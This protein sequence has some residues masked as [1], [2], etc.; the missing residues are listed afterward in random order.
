MKWK[1][2]SQSHEAAD[3]K[4]DKSGMVIDKFKFERLTP[5]DDIDLNIYEN[6]LDFAL[7]DPAVRNI[8][9]SGAYSSGKSS[10]LESYKK[11]HNGDKLFRKIK[12]LHISLAHFETPDEIN[13]EDFNNDTGN[14]TVSESILEG[15]I[16]NQLIHQIPAKRIPQTNF[17][18][19]K[20]TQTVKVIL[21]TFLLI[22]LILAALFI[23]NYSS[24]EHY[25]TELPDDRFRRLLEISIS[26]YSK[27]VAG[28]GNVILFSILIYN[29]IRLQNDRNILKK[30]SVQGNEIEIFENSDDSF[31][32]K[33]LNEVLY[34][35]ERVDA[36][37]IV[38]EDLDRFDVNR[39][40]ERLHEINTLVNSSKHRRGKKSPLRFLYL[41]RDDIFISKDRTKFFDFIIPVIPVMDGSNSYNILLKCFSES[42]IQDSFDNGFLQGLS[43]YIDDMR[44][45]KNIYNEFLIY[46]HRLNTTELDPNKMLAMI[47][48][49]NIFPRDFADLQLNR[50]FVYCLFDRKKEFIEKQS[51]IWK[52]RIDDIDKIIE[53][54]KAECLNSETEL[55]IVY[56]KKRPTDYFGHSSSLSDEDQIEYDKR[57][58][59]LNDRNEG[60]IAELLSEK[61][62]IEE[63]LLE[64]KFTQ[65]YKIIDN[66][67]AKEVFGSSS[68][69]EIGEK[70]DYNEIKRSDY[71][72]LLKYLIREGYID[73]TYAD[74]MTFFYENSLHRDDKIFLRSVTDRKAK[75][76]T[77][78]L[79]NPELVVKRLK[80]TDFDKEETLNF[81]LLSFLLSNKSCTMQLDRFISQLKS[82]KNFQFIS[83]YMNTASELPLFVNAVN[84]VW[85][86]MF[87]LAVGENL[88]SDKHI[89]DFSLNTLCCSDEAT[90]E[91]VNQ[92]DCLKEYISKTPD[93]LDIT[94]PEIEELI[95]VFSLLNVNFIGLDYEKSD[96]ALFM[97]VYEHSMYEI[98]AENL[99]LITRQ[100]IGISDTDDI[101]HKNYTILSE[102]PDEPIT[103]YVNQNIEEY[104]GVVLDMSSDSI[105]DSENVIID[106]LNNENISQDKRKRYIHALETIITNIEEITDLSL[107]S[108]L[109]D[110]G[111]VAFLE[112]NIASYFVKAGELDEH[113]VGFMNKGVSS[114]DFSNVKVDDIVKRNLF[115]KTLKCNEL[116]D[117]VYEQ[118]LS[119]IGLQYNESDFGE[120]DNQKV[121]ILID[122]DIIAVA[123]DILELIREKYSNLLKQFIFR[124]IEKYVKIM[125]P[126]L[127]SHDELLDVLDMDV[128]DELKLSLLEFD[129]EDI[130][131]LNKKYSPEV[132]KRILNKHLMVSDLDKLFK[133]YE[134]YSEDLKPQIRHLAI[135]YISNIIGKSDSVSSI[136]LDELFSAN[137]LDY[138]DKISLLISRMPML[139]ELEIKRIF[140]IIDL[141]EYQ[142][143]FDPNSRPH[144]AMDH[145]NDRILQALKN[146]NF[147][148]DYEEDNGKPGY[149]KITRLR[150]KTKTDVEK[151][152]EYL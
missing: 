120:M 117:D 137:E 138:D 2:D 139:S 95:R 41:I 53:E 118:V 143:I 126:H 38:F 37:V 73:E 141:P 35:F 7:K 99:Q 43:L 82:S 32:D 47:T 86:E 127:F 58:K 67:N 74:Y 23:C 87:A 30:L 101:I 146:N 60:R 104:I 10:V 93:Y 64:A 119:S 11:K 102:R 133:E 107:C 92:S 81:D 21:L 51:A 13:K 97:A 17:R 68:T 128:N 106:V 18:V 63:K 132:C 78:K 113:I 85:P 8:A 20:R 152:I 135:Q 125:E 45:L 55:R 103:T 94:N 56:D 14:D 44:L 72:D 134:R 4:A 19:K 29:L 28:A 69:N 39:I 91:N 15:K 83:G 122:N 89:R 88:L 109:L 145:V 36:D 25:I 16:L 105:A 111:S 66:N 108:I 62:S 96:K 98:N 151:E 90:I 149:Y 12:F 71:F 84:R 116:H 48:Y 79:Q 115:D 129:D 5:K 59:N 124:N 65:L 6:A 142:K 121:A 57:L 33:Y 50:G 131:I 40:F 42:G 31:F 114:L 77:Y 61:V 112:K 52:S 1:K 144:F 34:L 46:Y 3:N 70:N 130:S 26:P 123:P 27:L 150:K 54:Y 140:G 100:V 110:C 22:S 24:W 76:F 136:L 75:E 147:I 148:K 49:K 80:P 9:L